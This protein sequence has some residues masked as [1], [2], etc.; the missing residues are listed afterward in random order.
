MSS[1]EPAA[2]PAA[3][4]AALGDLTRL[5][6]VRT[7]SDGGQRSIASLS[8]GT[9]LTRQAVTK[10]L[11][12]LEQAGLV[13]SRRNGRERT[14]AFRPQPVAAART[15]LDQVSAHWHEALGRL[16]NLVED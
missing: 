4:F 3:V 5:S 12:V 9:S 13:S 6:L 15:Y 11:V 7:L 14:Y 10:H 8:A 2:A 16:R 1:G